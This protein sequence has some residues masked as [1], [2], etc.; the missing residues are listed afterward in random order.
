MKNACLELL[1]VQLDSYSKLDSWLRS[2]PQLFDFQLCEEASRSSRCE[3]QVYVSILFGAD[4]EF[5]GTR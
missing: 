4:F 1:E 5:P 2:N 3:H